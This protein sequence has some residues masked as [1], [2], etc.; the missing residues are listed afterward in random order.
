M[1]RRKK[2]SPVELTK[3]CLARIE[4]WNPKLNAFVTVTAESALAEAREA[5]AEIQR[6]RW[7]GPLHGIPIGLKDLFDTA[8]V[9]TTGG[10]ALY[11]DRI[12]T[13]D[14]EVVRRLKAAGA[15]LVGKNNMQEFAYGG[16]SIISYFGAVPNPWD[17][18]RI[19]GGS[20][21]GS[22]AAVAAGLCYGALGSDT[23]GSIR[24]PAAY[25]NLAGLKPTYGL[26]S[27]RGV[28]PLSWSLDHVG[29]LTRTVAD[30]AVM[31]QAIAGYD[32]AD[33]TSQDMKVPDYTAALRMKASSLRVGIVRDFFFEGID[34]EI[35]AAVN[36]ALAVLGKLTAGLRETTIPAIRNESVRAVVRAAE[37]YAYHAEFVAKTPELYQ[38]ETLKRIKPGA[39]VTAGAYIQGRR[40]LAQIRRAVR[41]VFDSVDLLVTPTTLIPPPVIA[42]LRADLR[43]DE[44][45]LFAKELLTVRN[46]APF[47][48]YG[49]PT[50]SIPCGFTSAGLPVGLQISGPHGGEA[51]VLQLAH[52]YEQATE[53]HQR[54]PALLS[55]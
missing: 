6:G 55:T 38:P 8:G 47:N 23:G 2:V 17:T 16:G 44:S 33:T 46:T 29:P 12:P 50:I 39:E 18:S 54:R 10:S 53:W 25:C 21:G 7:R 32:P 30:A 43:A 15:V 51:V 5:E 27:T 45:T 41:E 14:A 3:A 52:A 31:L 37:A 35:E 26:V 24:Q 19:A 49:L 28:I 1:V 11:K 34:R 22:A 40:D 48:V 9:R 13:E 42:D 20:S 36:D 4:Q